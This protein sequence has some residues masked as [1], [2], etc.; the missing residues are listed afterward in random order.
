ML[1][2]PHTMYS[3]VSFWKGLKLYF[4]TFLLFG[5]FGCDDSTE[6]KT[7]SV[8]RIVLEF[9]ENSLPVQSASGEKNEYVIRDS[10]FIQSMNTHLFKVTQDKTDVREYT[11]L[12]D[13]QTGII[14]PLIT[15]PLMSYDEL[16]LEQKVSIIERDFPQEGLEPVNFTFLPFEA[17]LNNMDFQNN[18]THN[19]ASIDSVFRFYLGKQFKRYRSPS[20]LD[21]LLSMVEQNNEVVDYAST[22]RKKI[23]VLKKRIERPNVFIY[24]DYW[25]H[26]F[27]YFEL[28]FAKN[29]PYFSEETIMQGLCNLKTFSF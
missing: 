20:S 8:N 10:L 27:E 11:I 17:F 2:K 9:I 1:V 13:N 6:K 3:L 26:E 7:E 15:L 24:Q 12:L 19:L 29:I 23:Q 18:R 5:N 14:Y 25:E 16:T 21:S 28:S 22:L 4:L